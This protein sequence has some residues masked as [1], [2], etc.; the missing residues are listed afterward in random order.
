[1][2]K[3][4]IMKA[5]RLW[6]FCKIVELVKC[7]NRKILKSSTQKKNTIT[8]HDWIIVLNKVMKLQEKLAYYFI[9]PP[10]MSYI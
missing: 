4:F 10:A 7:N 6:C 5:K 9:M 1:M 8:F 3:Y 2:R